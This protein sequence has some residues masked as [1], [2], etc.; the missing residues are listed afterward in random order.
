M[1][2]DTY[3]FMTRISFYDTDAMGVMHHASFFKLFEDARVTWLRDSGLSQFHYPKADMVLAVT[4]AHCSYKKTVIYDQEISIFM[5]V[6]R[7][8]LKL[9][10]QYAIYDNT[11]NLVAV[12]RTEHV[13]MDKNLKLVRYPN[14]FKVA[15][16]KEKWIETWP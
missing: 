4:E 11:N 13:P 14:D 3:K 9:L 15:L 6:K 7:T 16:E 12:G 5:Q 2:P 8:G 10:I 1:S